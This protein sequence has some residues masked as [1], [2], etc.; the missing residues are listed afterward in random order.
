MTSSDFSAIAS[1]NTG[2]H[3]VPPSVDAFLATADDDAANR[4]SLVRMHQRIRNMEPRDD[5]LLTIR[6][7]QREVDEELFP[8]ASVVAEELI[9][10]DHI[11]RCTLYGEWLEDVVSPVKSQCQRRYPAVPCR[12]VAD[13]ARP[14]ADL[15]E[16]LQPPRLPLA[17]PRPTPRATA[18]RGVTPSATGSVQ[19]AQ[20][21]TLER[22]QL[23]ARE[24]RRRAFAAAHLARERARQAFEDA[25]RL[26]HRGQVLE[27]QQA[28]ARARRRARRPS[29]QPAHPAA[30]SSLCTPKAR[31]YTSAKERRRH[32]WRAL[33][34]AGIILEPP[35]DER[36]LRDGDRT[37]AKSDAVGGAAAR[38]LLRA[39]RAAGGARQRVR[40]CVCCGV[41]VLELHEEAALVTGRQKHVGSAGERARCASTA[42]SC[43]R[44]KPARRT[45]L[46]GLLASVGLEGPVG[47][48][49]GAADASGRVLARST[50]IRCMGREYENTRRYMRMSSPFT[51]LDHVHVACCDCAQR[52]AIKDKRARDGALLG[53]QE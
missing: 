40:A 22:A 5:S 39:H 15:Y 9:I 50:R 26:A 45:N 46:R 49:D 37:V 36:R 43:R 1:L 35:L 16:A 21:V 28:A 14:R 52:S 44:P 13:R 3:T 53:A 51:V 42:A 11:F 18:E 32:R 8:D 2:A 12:A 24:Q 31:L 48:W 33:R 30:R 19:V 23:R 34:G 41:T 38:R 20:R 47:I 6:F 17:V 4:A 27:A 29:Q 10:V 25:L 7:A